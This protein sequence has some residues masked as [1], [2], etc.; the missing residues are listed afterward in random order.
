MKSA[1][2][3]L[4]ARAD[5]DCNLRGSS[6]RLG[7][8]SKMGGKVGGE[9]NNASSR[10]LFDSM[11]RDFY[12]LACSYLRQERDS[13]RMSPTS[14]VHEAFIRIVDQSEVDWR[15]KTHFFALGA[16]I[17]R[18][19]LVDSARH[20]N[21]QKRGGG[22]QRVQLSD[23]LY[24]DLKQDA[25]VLELDELLRKLEELDPKQAKIVELRFFGG[26]TMSEI[27]GA[28]DSSLLSIERDWLMARAWL[29]AELAG[30]EA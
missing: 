5:D 25:Q 12:R 4:I 22:W 23:S 17:M 18:Q 7:N 19:L 14:L 1:T 2:K 28:L 26:M 24:F 6:K 3:E 16:R 9:S 21:A 27:A 20:R 15:G 8:S 13:R 11:Y 30:S 10:S 29:R